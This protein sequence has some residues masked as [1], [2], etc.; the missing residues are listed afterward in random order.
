[1]AA[2]VDALVGPKGQHNAGRT[3]VRHGVDQGYLY[4]GDRNVPVIH[5]RVRTTTG[6]E[7]HVPSLPRPGGGLLDGT[8]NACS[9]GWP[10][11]QHH[12]DPAL[13]AYPP[14]KPR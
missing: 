13:A 12:A 3:A 6:D 4:L 14:A 11:Q 5:P 9:S 2:E 1:M 7:V 10:V 8:R